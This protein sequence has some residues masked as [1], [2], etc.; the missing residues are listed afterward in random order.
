MDEL[1]GVIAAPG[2]QTVLFENDEV[3]VVDL[4]LRH[5]LE[6]SGDDPIVI[7]GVELKHTGGA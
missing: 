1:H 3:R 6:N 5:T 7:S 4:R 2:I